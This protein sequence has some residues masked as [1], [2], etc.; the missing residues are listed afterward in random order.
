VLVLHT[1]VYNILTIKNVVRP[2]LKRH[3]AND[4]D[5]SILRAL[6]KTLAHPSEEDG[7]IFETCRGNVKRNDN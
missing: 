5:T 7:K 1:E 6:E 3:T 2:L 4:Y